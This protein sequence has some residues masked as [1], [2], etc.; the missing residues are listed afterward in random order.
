[1]KYGE[2]AK[3]IIKNV[4]GTDNILSLAHCITRLR[5]K[6]KDEKK[7]N[8]KILQEMDGVVTVIQSG[9]QYQVVIGNHVPDVYQAVM[10][11]GNISS[12]ENI[13]DKN[14]KKGKTSVLNALIDIVSGIFAPCLG[15][16]AAT[17]MVKGLS[18]LLLSLSMISKDSGTYY[19]LSAIGDS[20]FYFFPVFLGYTSAKKFD[21]NVFTGM[22]IGATLVYPTIIS[23]ASGEPLY[24]LFEG[25]II[26]SPIYVTFLGIPVILMNYTSSVMPIILAN[27]VA[28]KLEKFL[29]KIIPDVVK[30]F[31]LPMIVLVIIIPLTLL[32]LGPISTWVSQVIGSANLYIYNLSPIIAGFLMGGLWQILV[33]FGLHWGFIP[34][35]INNRTLLGYDPIIPLSFAASFAQIGV[36]LAIFLKTKNAKEKSIAIPAFISGIFGVTEPAIYGVT[37]P[38]KI[39]F[40]ISCVAGAIGGAIIGASN[41]VSYGMSGLGIFGFP[42]Y[43]SPETGIN[44]S[45]YGIIIAIMVAFILGFLLMFIIKMDKKEDKNNDNNEKMSIKQVRKYKICSP[46]KGKIIALKNISDEAFSKGALGE[47]V[48]IC[49]VEGK[50]VSPIDGKIVTIFSTN[51]AIGM[52]SD[53]GVEIL[54]HIGVDTIKLNG[55]YFTP[56]V[57]VG[58]TV[59]KGDLILEFDI[60]NIQK[61]GYE[62]VTPIIVT[63]NKDYLEIIETDE[64]NINYKDKLLTII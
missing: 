7:A 51:H 10:Q 31:L 41:G 37:L 22:A 46:M 20:F 54:I 38:R 35:V 36:V 60:E 12:V 48:A 63:N 17:G 6:L 53:D 26:E 24:T 64:K 52:I 19:I 29:K 33:I 16:L 49:P 15:V 4:G 32:V 50:V 13:D 5:F 14:V 1:M 25:T 56:K 11:I 2:L 23:M 18:A 34:I 3:K 58:D 57:A 47:G 62:I 59:K 28:S 40:A 27:Y 45:F 61:E 44:K 30:L 43:I 55:K 42:S 39:P 9:G 8:T 21:L